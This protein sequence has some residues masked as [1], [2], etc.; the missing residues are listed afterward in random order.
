MTDK[1]IQ[2]VF[3]Q[4]EKEVTDKEE[5][6]VIQFEMHKRFTSL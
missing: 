6:A 3:G 2:E 1:T 4:A 5:M